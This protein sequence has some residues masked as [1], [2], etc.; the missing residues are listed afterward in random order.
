MAETSKFSPKAILGISVLP[1]VL[2]I[3]M[4]VSGSLTV[5]EDKDL[6]KPLVGYQSALI[7][8]GCIGVI[9]GVVLMALG[10]ARMVKGSDLLDVGF[11]GRNALGARRSWYPD[12]M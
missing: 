5:K 3:M 12:M 7:A 10:I 6:T 11:G 1:F 9:V 2:G 4:I 8:F